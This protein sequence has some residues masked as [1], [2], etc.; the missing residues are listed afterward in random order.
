[1]VTFC[2]TIRAKES[3]ATTSVASG[4]SKNTLMYL[5]SLTGKNSTLGFI[6]AKNTMEK[7]NNPNVPANSFNGCLPLRAQFKI[8]EYR[9]SK[10]TKNLSWKVC[11]KGV[12]YKPFT[13]FNKAKTR[14][15]EPNIL[16]PIR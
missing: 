13:K 11:D 10:R 9:L 3:V 1:M 2:S 4:I 8:L 16:N 6:K 5:G 12:R 7:I 14:A 15:K